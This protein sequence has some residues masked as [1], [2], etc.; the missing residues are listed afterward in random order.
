MGE[1]AKVFHK[2]GIGRLSGLASTTALIFL[3]SFV[4]IV[5]FLNWMQ[6]GSPLIH[7]LRNTKNHH[8]RVKVPLNCTHAALQGRKCPPNYPNVFEPEDSSTETCPDYF[9]WIHHD[10]QQWKTTGITQDMIERG[11][12][13]AHFRLVIV[14]GNVYVEKYSRPF[15][16]R[17]LFTKWGILQLLRLYTGK[18]PDLDLLFFSGDRA[19]IMK[20]DYQG[21]N[22]TLAPPVFRYCGS[23]EALDI[24]F[25]D[26]TFWGWAEVNIMPWEYTLRAIKKGT[27]RLKWKDREPYAF[28]K[29]NPYVAED[30]LDLMKCNVS[31]KFDWN[32]RLFHQNWSRAT[33]EGFQGSKL[34]DQCHYSMMLMIKPGYY[35][36]FSRSLVPLQHYW[37]IR[38]K[39]KCRGLKF[40]VEWGNK[41]SQQ[42]Q[43]IGKAGSK[44]IQ[45][46]L[47]IRNV[48][49]YMY[50]LLN[51]YS[52]LLKFKPTKP[53]KARRICVES[54]GCP[55]KGLW[56]EFMEQSIV[57]SPSNKLP[58]ALPPPYE[59]QAI[60]A[61]LDNKEK[62]AKRVEKWET[63]YWSKLNG[64]RQ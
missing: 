12:S 22:A 9:Q 41:H 43:A 18:V 40:A 21:P 56:R 7:I 54:L 11:K 2:L 45:E 33:Q 16:S 23:E 20:R 6:I 46:L 15:Q 27:E 38:H 28:W 17:D 25:P 55:K 26:W 60:R 34:E 32:V 31:D 35:D 48:Y 47:T 64:T 14:G 24:V 57:K 39:D 36:F 50:H 10:L 29:G 42:A 19:K 62:M 61:F 30:R 59:P 5:A 44:F 1:H 53:P 63:E 8:E 49:D 13:S 37:P 3:F 51:E 52:K 58:C 4:L